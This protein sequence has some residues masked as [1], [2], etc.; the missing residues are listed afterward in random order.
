MVLPVRRT[1]ALVAILALG[2]CAGAA[3]P[4]PLRI[5]DLR[6]GREAGFD[7]MVTDLAGARVVYVGE[8]HDR[9]EH[10]ELQA[11]I[12]RALHAHDPSLAVGM[13]MF[14]RPFQ[15]ALDAFVA[16]RIDEA[17]LLRRTEWEER[18]GFGFEMYRP[19]L[20]HARAHGLA[21]VALNAPK[22]LTRA[23]ARRGLGGLDD[24]ER[25][26]LPEI[27]EGD[28]RHR[29]M[30]RAALEGH[31]GLDDELLGRFV[32]AQLVWDE[33]M[34][35]AVAETLARDGAPARMVVLAGRMHVL[36]GRGVPRRAAR[37]GA[38]PF[39][40]VLPVSADDEL[41]AWR[42]PEDERPAD[43]LVVFPAPE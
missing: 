24:E 10:H 28:A 30:V 19:I 2:A 6:T 13:E 12:V 33:T 26:A 38:E 7:R 5:V 25:Q 15:A 4:E 35:E 37:R 3:E 29:D 36:E 11:S 14:Q 42:G 40:I 23:V 27:D 21:V 43:W 32:A 16:G 34:A 20:E 22:E 1:A 17:E 41:A 18:W 8:E 31:P 39:R 9:P